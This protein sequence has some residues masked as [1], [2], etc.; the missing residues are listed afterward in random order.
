MIKDLDYIEEVIE[1]AQVLARY[2]QASSLN[3]FYTHTDYSSAVEP[4]S[5]DSSHYISVNEKRVQ[6]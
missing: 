4:C 6:V 3:I 2:P 5:S 1:E